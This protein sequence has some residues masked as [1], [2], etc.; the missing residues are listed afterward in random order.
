MASQKDESEL[1]DHWDLPDTVSCLGVMIKLCLSFLT[2]C[3]SYVGTIVL[4]TVP[5]NSTATK[6]G[7]LFSYYIVL[8][9]WAAQGLGMSLLSR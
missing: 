1:A 9:F 7:L 8:S 4:M 3:R 5:N 6:A 2:I